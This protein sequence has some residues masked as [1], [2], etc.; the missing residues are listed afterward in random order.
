M[1]RI[2]TVGHRASARLADERG[3][4]PDFE[5]SRLAAQ[6]LRLRNAT[7]TSIAPTGTI[8]MLA[9][10]SS[11]IEPYFALAYTRHVLDGAELPETN[12]RCEAALQSAHWRAGAVDDHYRIFAHDD[13]SP[14]QKGANLAI[15][16]RFSQGRWCCNHQRVPGSNSLPRTAS[17]YFSG[18]MPLCRRN[19]WEK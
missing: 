15:D 10:C 11:G 2:Q 5:G 17:R 7:V 14:G 19:S 16:R 3:V 13:S 1:S 6:G 4:F 12:R 9:D 8:S 18:L